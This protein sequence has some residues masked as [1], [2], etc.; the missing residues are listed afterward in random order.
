MSAEE[1]EAQ[2]APETKEIPLQA[3][4]LEGDFLLGPVS[5][6]MRARD[7]A[8]VSPEASVREAAERMGAHDVGCVLVTDD[9]GALLGILTE[10]DVLTRVVQEGRDPIRETVRMH[11][12]PNPE[13]LRLE[14]EVAYALNAMAV[15][16][17]RHVPILDHQDRLRGI[18]S[19]R[20]IHRAI[21]RHFEREIL[22]LPPRPHRRARATSRYGA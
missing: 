4:A 22:N 9:G 15:G 18:I 11:M 2:L 12:T 16:G 8:T 21:T 5:G 19:I 20:D 6:L 14:D 13:C 7:L 10:R 17:Y 1:V 3:E